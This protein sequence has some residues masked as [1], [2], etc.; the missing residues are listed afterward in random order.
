MFGPHIW[1][2]STCRRHELSSVTLQVNSLDPEL[3]S[4]FDMCA[5]DESLLKDG[6]KPKVFYDFVSKEELAA[7]LKGE[8]RTRGKA[9]LGSR[10]VPPGLVRHQLRLALSGLD[11]RLSREKVGSRFSSKLQKDTHIRTRHICF[12]REMY[13]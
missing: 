2:L 11:M 13:L 12:V 7:A 1:D 10:S 3:R 6:K 9:T 4:L 5:I 8:M